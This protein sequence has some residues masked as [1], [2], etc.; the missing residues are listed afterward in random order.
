MRIAVLAKSDSA[1]TTRSNCGQGTGTAPSAGA[2]NAGWVGGLRRGARATHLGLVLPR[3]ALGRNLRGEEGGHGGD[4]KGAHLQ[5]GLAGVLGANRWA[6]L[7]RERPSVQLIFGLAS[8]NSRS[9]ALY[10]LEFVGFH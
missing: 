8:I 5:G 7:P 2:S 6:A 4:G 9:C 10:C 1:D 3:L